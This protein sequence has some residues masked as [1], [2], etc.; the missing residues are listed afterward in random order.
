MKGS[1]ALRQMKNQKLAA[2]NSA[3]EAPTHHLD[4]DI[5]FDRA[6]RTT[7]ISLARQVV[8]MNCPSRGQVVPDNEHEVFS[9]PH[10]NIHA[11]YED[12]HLSQVT[13]GVERI[14][15][16]VNGY[17]I[18][19]RRAGI[20]PCTE[21]EMPKLIASAQELIGLSRAEHPN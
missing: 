11:A 16:A 21:I 20:R 6:V 8:D 14:E 18:L 4:D 2:A 12:I 13:H 3:Y 17:P 9:L 5:E 1:G 10:S 19:A 7:A 15:A